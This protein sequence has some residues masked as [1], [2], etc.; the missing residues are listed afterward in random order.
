M[1]KLYSIILCL[2]LAVFSASLAVADDDDSD[3][4]ITPAPIPLS[5]LPAH[6]DLTNKQMAAAITAKI[7]QDLQRINQPQPRPHLKNAWLKT[8]ILN[9]VNTLLLLISIVMSI[10]LLKKQSKV[11]NQGLLPQVTQVAEPKISADEYDFMNSAEG[12]T[13]KLDLVRAY[14]AMGEMTSAKETLT[15]VLRKGNAEQRQQAKSLLD[16]ILQSI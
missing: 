11:K 14:I 5:P 3:A 13:A 15:E 2:L 4:S 1:R 8:N 6:D 12:M 7:E 10:I 16:N 9:L